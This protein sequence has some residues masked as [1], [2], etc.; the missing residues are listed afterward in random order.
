MTTFYTKDIADR[1]RKLALFQ[2]AAAM[3]LE[4]TDNE[5]AAA[6]LYSAT[7]ENNNMANDLRDAKTSFEA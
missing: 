4:A 7:Q 5:D 1:L 2:E 6:P 3:Q